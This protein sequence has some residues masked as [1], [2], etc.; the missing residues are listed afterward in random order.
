MNGG[1]KRRALTPN[2]SVRSSPLR[3]GAPN[4]RGGWT[5]LLASPRP[6]TADVSDPDLVNALAQASCDFDATGADPERNCWLAVHR[7]MHGVLPSE[8]DIRDI[9]EDLYLAVLACRLGQKERSDSDL[10]DASPSP[11]VTGRD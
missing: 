1:R 4:R 10:K 2:P 11:Q 7:H 6:V 5:E 8:Y 9:D 3:M